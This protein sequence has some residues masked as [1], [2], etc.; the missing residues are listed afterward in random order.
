VTRTEQL[1]HMEICSR[2]GLG[3]LASVGRLGGTRSVSFVFRTDKGRWLVRRR[4]EG[5]C[6]PE[7][8]R[9]DHEAARFLAQNGAAVL[10]PLPTPDG[11]VCYRNDSGLWEVYPFVKGRR[12]ADGDSGDVLALAKSLARLHEAGRSFQLRCDKL[13]PR[14]ETD[15]DGLLMDMQRLEAESPDAAEALIPYRKAVERAAANLPLELYESLP[16]T[17]VHG[18]VQPAN[19]LMNDEA[20]AAFVDLDWL[21]WRPRIYDL[22]FAILCCCARHAKPIGA[23]DIWLL[24]QTPEFDPGVAVGF[25]SVYESH[26]TPLTSDER[27]SLPPQVMLTWSHV[28]VGCALKAPERERLKLLTRDTESDGGASYIGRI[29]RS[30][31]LKPQAIKRAKAR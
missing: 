18:D 21:A 25:L 31:T 24:S 8:L 7:R 1:E 11:A 22:A 28:R 19:V 26:S 30:L 2:F 12:L 27:K 9:F 20:V 17:L 14:G 3:E 4:F 29:M 10:A 15:P 5:Y 16:H 23:G 13:G 6:D